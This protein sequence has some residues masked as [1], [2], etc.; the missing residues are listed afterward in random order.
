MRFITLISLV[1]LLLLSII[2]S[3]AQPDVEILPAIYPGSVEEPFSTTTDGKVFYSKDGFAKSNAYYVQIYGAPVVF[4]GS[5]FYKVRGLKDHSADD[6]TNL[7]FNVS[8]LSEL[9]N[10]IPRPEYDNH[11]VAQALAGLKRAYLDKKTTPFLKIDP[12]Q[13]ANDPIVRRTYTKYAYLLHRFFAKTNVTGK[14]G[15]NKGVEELLYEKYFAE[16]E[17][18]SRQKIKDL[19]DSYV[20][21]IQQG[22]L[23]KATEISK[24]LNMLTTVSNEN[25]D[26]KWDNIL[27]FL[28]ELERLSFPTMIIIYE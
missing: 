27:A 12:M 24:E 14:S 7:N 17:S 26:E 20:S 10:I 21:T 23:K 18:D 11:H 28:Q 25:P 4:E 22:D 16:P 9:I 5:N 3:T 2:S 13:F 8:N 6:S 19:Q 1:P 15:A